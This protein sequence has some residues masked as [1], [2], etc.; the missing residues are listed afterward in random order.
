MRT[1][2]LA[3]H[4]A[5]EATWNRR[6]RCVWVDAPPLGNV[7]AACGLLLSCRRAKIADV[8]VWDI[9]FSSFVP[10]DKGPKLHVGN[11]LDVGVWRGWGGLLDFWHY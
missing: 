5:P 8:D 1:A 3:V 7:S 2:A 11:S 6:Q 9:H 10:D 4:G